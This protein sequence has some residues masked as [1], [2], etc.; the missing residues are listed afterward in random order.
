MTIRSTAISFCA[1]SLTGML[2]AV[3]ANAEKDPFGGKFENYQCYRV[4]KE[5]FKFGK[6]RRVDVKDQFG[7]YRQFAANP[8]M[9]CNPVSINGEPIKEPEVHLTCFR[10]D[11]AQNQHL[12]E[13]NVYVQ[14]RFGEGEVLLEKVSQLLC[15]TSTK[16][17]L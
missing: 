15:V 10:T 3:P 1:A 4:I 13:Q 14:N 17:H 8:V 12:K 9:V 5:D 16:K 6:E 11:P 7:K 2:L